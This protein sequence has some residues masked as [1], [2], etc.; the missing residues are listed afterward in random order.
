MVDSEVAVDA[1]LSHKLKRR[2]LGLFK[3]SSSTALIQK[4]AKH[5]KDAEE[6]YNLVTTEEQQIQ[7]NQTIPTRRSS[8]ASVCNRESSQ[9]NKKPSTS[10]QNRRHQWIKLAL[11]EKKLVNIV[12]H[13]AENSSKYYESGALMSNYL[14]AQILC[15]LLVG[16]A[17]IEFSRSK[18]NDHYNFDDPTADELLK[19]HKLA[20]PIAC[21]CQPKSQLMAGPISVPDQTIS[22]AQ[23][24]R[25]VTENSATGAKL[26][27]SNLSSSLTACTT[28]GQSLQ[29]IDPQSPCIMNNESNTLGQFNGQRR[30]PLSLKTNVRRGTLVTD[31]YHYSCQEFSEHQQT[32]GYSFLNTSA[33]CQPFTGQSTG[34]GNSLANNGP[35]RSSPAY[36]PVGQQA[37]V[38]TEWPPWS[39]RML[40]E[41]L[42]Q[43]ARSRLLYAKNN[44]LLEAQPAKSM[45][46][47]LSL[48]QTC[49]D[50]VL[51]WIPNQMINGIKVGACCASSDSTCKTSKLV[52]ELSS[53][54]PSGK[55]EHSTSECRIGTNTTEDAPTAVESSYLD[56]VVSLSVSRIVLLHCRFGSPEDKIYST[57]SINEKPTVT[58]VVAF[59]GDTLIL[60]EA[61]GVQKAPFI[62]PKGGLKLFLSCLESGLSPNKY[63]D[64]AIQFGGHDGPPS[65]DPIQCLIEQDRQEPASSRLGLILRRLP[66]I[67]RK[68]AGSQLATGESPE[69]TTQK[70][71][72]M[73][74]TESAITLACN[75]LDQATESSKMVTYVYRIVSIQKA[76]WPAAQTPPPHSAVSIDSSSG[77]S[78]FHN[79]QKSLQTPGGYHQK[80][81]WSLSKLARFSHSGSTSSSANSAQTAPTPILASKSSLTGNGSTD[82]SSAY[83]QYNSLDP[84][85]DYEECSSTSATVNA[86]ST[87][88]K[89]LARFEA[90]LDDLKKSTSDH[91]LALRTQSV[92]TLCDSMRKQILARAFY[93]WLVHC[94]KMKIIRA[95]LMKLLKSHSGAEDI[96]Q[97]DHEPPEE[98][99]TNLA[100][101]DLGSGLTK[102]SWEH[103]M[104]ERE[105]LEE[106]E[107]CQRVNALVYY[108]TIENDELRKEVWP[109]LLGHYDFK[110]GPEQREHKDELVSETYRKCSSAWNKVERVVKQRD[111]ELLAANMA[112]V[113]NER[114][115]RKRMILN[116]GE[117]C[118]SSKTTDSNNNGSS[119]PFANGEADKP[120]V[121][122]SGDV[123]SGG[124]STITQNATI[125]GANLKENFDQDGQTA[126]DEGQSSCNSLQD[127]ERENYDLFDDRGQA[128]EDDQRSH[129]DGSAPAT[130]TK[131]RR[132]RRPRLES[133]GSVGSDASITDQFGNN[134]HRI[135]KDVQR[136]D[137]N[138]WYFK[139]TNNLEKLRNIM[140][141]YVWQHLEIGYVQGMCD[142]AAPFLVIFDDE[143]MAFSCFSRLMERMVYNFPHGCAMDQHFES[144]KHLM[145]VLDPRLYEV[146]QSNGD[147]TH[148]YFCYRWLLLDF[149]RGE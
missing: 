11:I 39:P 25:S 64:P 53:N 120:T 83:E 107:L 140:C 105:K 139:D 128:V 13:L 31:C 137:R 117:M 79:F 50:L 99:K 146:L 116:Q 40:H 144:L 78:Y 92:Q 51:K 138:F 1:C 18:T 34:N 89:D 16:P 10:Q 19:R 44:V 130:V 126:L 43:N 14:C 103:I 29:V 106:F 15:S 24:S 148:F 80:F 28:Y 102:T 104:K 9:S 115:L 136:C 84:L 119:T 17:A 73:A 45:A 61:D 23:L 118:N 149:K 111:Q 68:S 7:A 62:F 22:H 95:H 36:I 76:G 96:E 122:D 59:K 52:E 70:N 5:C 90:K 125:S 37:G 133:T 98:R 74:N 91:I 30:R 113:V 135:D 108:G 58:D 35:S 124:T 88:S 121:V 20:N 41:T 87:S 85:D 55:P 97:Q 81:R 46:G 101:L 63:L 72:S 67:R 143:L 110:D 86:A 129:T 123:S 127:N 131:R 77:S 38:A 6:V 142:L 94:R 4:V 114:D 3:T 75:Q 21:L 54:S 48:H 49:T 100:D 32:K 69:Q 93:G 65:P 12:E 26:E 60:V 109:Y 2:A 112:K 141:T 27:H 57:V 66:S 147:Y 33:S 145:Q 71:S 42:H 8:V 132:K 47:Y 134:V 82:L 56:L